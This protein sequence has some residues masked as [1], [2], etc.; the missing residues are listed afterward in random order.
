MLKS[1][2]GGSDAQIT[3]CIRIALEPNDA[4]AAIGLL[5]VPYQRGRAPPRLHSAQCTTPLKTRTRAPWDVLW[6]LHRRQHEP[7][8]RNPREPTII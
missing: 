5:M 1:F 2:G 7:S 3:V 6:V 4:G 8:Q